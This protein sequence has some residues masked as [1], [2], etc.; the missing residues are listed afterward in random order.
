[1]STNLFNFHVISELL[2]APHYFILDLKYTS[3]PRR[4]T[5]I[6][7]IIITITIINITIIIITII[8]IAIMQSIL[9]FI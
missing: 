2:F 3:S 1:M 7:I 5:I 6:I 8:I 9:I 4:Y